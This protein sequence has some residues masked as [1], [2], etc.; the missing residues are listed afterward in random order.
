MEKTPSIKCLFALIRSPFVLIAILLSISTSCTQKQ[1]IQYTYLKGILAWNRQDWNTAVIHFSSAEQQAKKLSG[2]DTSSAEQYSHYTAFA[3]ASSYLVQNEDKAATQK[4]AAI[5]PTADKQLMAVTYYQQGIMAFRLKNY[6]EA[7]RFF[8]QSLEIADSDFD[9]KKN[10]ELCNRLCHYQEEMQQRPI[11]PTHTQEDA[12]TEHAII[13]N[14]ARQ[15][16]ASTWHTPH[17]DNTA[18]INDF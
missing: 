15:Q 3:L 1:V 7:A 13:L 10:Y 14:V 18:A 6:S 5:P 2:N 11:K 16:E 4:I 8:K 9:T 17:Q 12:A